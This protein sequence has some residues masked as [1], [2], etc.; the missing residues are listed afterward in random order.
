MPDRK[1]EPAVAMEAMD[2]M[3][4][5][6]PQQGSEIDWRI[7]LGM[8]LT[9]L[10]LLL[11]GI[12]VGG[13]VGWESFSTAPMELMGGFLEGAFAPLALLW[14]VIGYFLQKKELTQNTA[15]LRLQFMETR[16]AAE[17]AVIQSRAIA[18]SESHQRK[19]SFLRIWEAVSAQLGAI[20]GFQYLSSQAT[21]D[22]GDVP[23]E[24]LAELWYSMGPQDRE[25]FSR[26]MLVLRARHGPRYFYKVL[27]GTPLR[28]SHTEKFED[29]FRRL[30]AEA[31]DCDPGGMIHDAL[32]GSA[33][34]YLYLEIQRLRDDIPTGFTLGVYDFDPDSRDD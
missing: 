21:S 1:P 8:G 32:L 3:L 18:A 27:F 11:L 34:G 12:F 5:P 23:R 30:L 16:K 28:T 24:R 22:T 26:E 10:Y 4:A 7:V 17:Q 14:L 13:H 33:H 15:A 20:M 31:R 2:P 9:G 25:V 29:T 6:Y 19:E